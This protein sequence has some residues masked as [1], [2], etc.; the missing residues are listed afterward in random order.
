MIAA[1]A[2]LPA[3][4][5]TERIRTADAMSDDGARER[6]LLA[7]VAALR[8][9]VE[10]LEDR[11]RMLTAEVAELRARE[12]GLS[13]RLRRLDFLVE[14]KDKQ[15]AALREA[16]RERDEYRARLEKARA[17]IERLRR[18]IEVLRTSASAAPADTPSR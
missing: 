11:N 12:T 8:A 14:Q 13:E 1:L 10:H 16:P 15:I 7:E 18:E 6:Q 2:I 9:D 3:A 5:C 4:G 17:E